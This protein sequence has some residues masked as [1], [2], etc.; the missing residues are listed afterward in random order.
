[1][2]NVSEKIGE[3]LAQ[4]I[5]RPPAD[6]KVMRNLAG[7]RMGRKGLVTRAR[8]LAATVALLE[9]EKEQPI[10]LSAVARGASLGMTALYNY[11]SDLTE[12]LLAV[13]EPVMDTAEEAYMAMLR[14]WWPDDQLAERCLAFVS[15][16]HRFW[17]QH[18]RLLHL[19]NAM[20]DQRDERMILHR[21]ESTRPV[22]A[23]IVGQMVKKPQKGPSPAAA[24]AT[25]VEKTKTLMHASR[26]LVLFPEGTR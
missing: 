5:A 23:L 24:M 11:F 20:A 2:A 7:Q 17:A 1:M 10:T 25:M 15:A 21:I 4:E 22:I 6:D 8:I 3:R 12:L 18:S 14:D 19:R 13:L 16:Y 9:S 26:V